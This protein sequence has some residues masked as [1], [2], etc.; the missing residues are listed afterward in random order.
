MRAVLF[1][2][3]AVLVFLPAVSLGEI[4]YLKDGSTLQGELRRF[5]NDTLYVKT[6]FG[7]EV[8]IHKTHVVRIDFGA[9]AT[10]VLSSPVPAPQTGTD[11]EAPPMQSAVPGTLQVEF[12]DFSLSSTIIADRRQ[13]RK[14]VQRANAIEHYLLVDGRKVYSSVDTTMDK[15]IREGPQTQLRNKIHPKGYKVSLAEG[16]YRFDFFFGNTMAGEYREQFAGGDGLDKRLFQQDVIVR[17][18]EVTLIR[19]GLKKK[20]KGL[21]ASYLYVMQ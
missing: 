10:G 18:G 15:V 1:V 2:V 3:V 20:L 6:S 11:S 14:A 4:F 9:V 8:T 16:R 17:S 13:D 7:S 21:G 5:S 19:V 12:D